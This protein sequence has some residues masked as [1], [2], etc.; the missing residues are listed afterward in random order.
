MHVVL[1]KV[2]T[3]PAERTLARTMSLD[4]LVPA[5]S[6]PVQDQL[7][8]ADSSR[9]LQTLLQEVAATRESLLAGVHGE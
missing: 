4:C 6:V 9:P 2:V 8:P 3:T 5:D 7:L 1:Q